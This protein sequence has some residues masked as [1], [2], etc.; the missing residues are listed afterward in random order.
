MSRLRGKRYL[1]S[2]ISIDNIF[3]K[4]GI[5]VNSLSYMITDLWNIYRCYQFSYDKLHAMVTKLE[6]LI[7][8]TFGSTK[9]LKLVIKIASNPREFLIDLMSENR[10][11]LS[12]QLARLLM[13][14]NLNQARSVVFDDSLTVGSAQQNDE[15]KKTLNA[16]LG[17]L[18][19]KA[20]NS[21][22][23]LR[24]QLADTLKRSQETESFD[25]FRERQDTP[26]LDNWLNKINAIRQQTAKDHLSVVR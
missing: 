19:N 24:L 23:K 3:R 1:N 4:S 6:S 10:A 22:P 18:K 9:N 21:D 15:M 25:P 7:T 20:K 8:K 12:D 16:M 26:Q 11:L 14:K 2:L 5:F 13:T 17:S